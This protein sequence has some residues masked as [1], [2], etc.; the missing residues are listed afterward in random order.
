MIQDL[1]DANRISSGR[2]LPLHP[3]KVDLTQVAQ[4]SLD[5]LTT[6]FGDHFRLR[7]DG[8][9]EGEW[10]PGYLRRMIENLCS[11]AVKY[12]SDSAP[13]TVEL[14]KTEIEN[15][16]GAMISVH[17][18]G[19]PLDPVEREGIFKLFHRSPNAERSRQQ[20]WGIGLTIV[21]GIASAHGGSVEV[22]SS[23]ETGT[24]FRVSL[25]RSPKGANSI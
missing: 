15:G 14:T 13:V 22:E 5:D 1:L 9:L 25:P 21:K 7:S 18:E 2:G 8:P 16:P 19:G 23:A 12:G 24:T 4:A 10:D 6:V 11:N 17:N 3:E 20:G